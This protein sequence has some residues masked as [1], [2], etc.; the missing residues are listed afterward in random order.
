[1]KVELHID[2]H[3]SEETAILQGPERSTNLQQVADFIQ[4]LEQESR[5]KA[6]Q[7][8]ERYLIEAQHFYR[9]YVENRQVIG[10][11]A[12]ETYILTG[13]LYKVS[14]DLPH[15]FLKISQSE[16]INTKQID[17]L[18]F[19]PSGS[20]AIHLSNDAISYS[21]RRYLKSIKEALS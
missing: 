17:H 10:Q 12:T 2:P 3:L 13:P 18:H 16:L 8:E 6:R 20:V 7:G 21:S 4:Q 9:I 15:Y 5:L 11:T 1:M 19:T 14:Q